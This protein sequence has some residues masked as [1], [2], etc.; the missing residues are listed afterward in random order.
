[1]PALNGEQRGSSLDWYLRVLG[2]GLVSKNYCEGELGSCTS[3]G[4]IFVAAPGCRAKPTPQRDS[5]KRIGLRFC[6]WAESDLY[7]LTARA[8]QQGGQL[9]FGQSR[10]LGALRKSPS[11]ILTGIS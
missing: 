7:A 9:A 5:V 8:V 6:F 2:F 11:A 4:R 3:R 1:M 10:I